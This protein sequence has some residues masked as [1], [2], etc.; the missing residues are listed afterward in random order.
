[1]YDF[2]EV[3]QNL[4]GEENVD[5]ESLEQKSVSKWPFESYEE[6]VTKLEEILE[7][8]QDE[9]LSLEENVKLYEEG[10]TLHKKLLEF[11]EEQ[12][13]RVHNMKDPSLDSPIDDV[14]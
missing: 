14:F 12:E 13:L 4:F 10:M 8:I 11:L 3:Q 7:K 1:M 2:D 9:E 5:N 6:G